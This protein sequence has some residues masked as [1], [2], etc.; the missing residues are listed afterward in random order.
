MQRHI[1]A[2]RRTD[3]NVSWGKGSEKKERGRGG[4]GSIFF[5]SDSNQSER[6]GGEGGGDGVVGR[7]VLGERNGD[8]ATRGK[9]ERRKET[10]APRRRCLHPR[11]QP[12]TKQDRFPPFLFFGEGASLTALLSSGNG[13]VGGRGLEIKWNG[14]TSSSS[15]VAV[16]RE[17]SGED[18]R[19]AAPQES[20]IPGPVQKLSPP[21]FPLTSLRFFKR[22][23][24]SPGGSPPA[25]AERTFPTPSPIPSG[26]QISGPRIFS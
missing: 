18:G 25:A 7:S 23:R 8:G 12:T 11:L 10:S 24:G 15:W 26:I 14:M 6:A 3:A 20:W 4:L 9:R 13:G 21:L 22:S 5:D 2:S 16:A 17:K 19:G 1:R